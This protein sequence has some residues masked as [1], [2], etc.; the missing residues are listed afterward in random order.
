MN[1]KYG[2]P[3]GIGYTNAKTATSRLAEIVL[4][5]NDAG[6]SCIGSVSM[7]T[8]DPTVLENVKRSNIKTSEYEKMITFLQDHDIPVKSDVMIGLPGQTP[9]TV[10]ADLQ[11]FFDRKVNA[12]I[13]A[14]AI[15]PNSPMGEPEYRDRYQIV[16]AE[17]GHVVSTHSFT[18]SD[19]E[20]IVDI[21]MAY[22]FFVRMSLAKYILYF[23]QI[24]HGVKAADFICARLDVGRSAE[25]PVAARVL[26]QML[27][28][29]R[30]N[31]DF[32]SPSWSDTDAAFL[33]DDLDAF[34][35]E[36]FGIYA[37]RFGAVPEAS[38]KAAIVAAQKSVM[39]NKAACYPRMIE[40]P[41]DVVGY[42]EQLR[43]VSD[44]TQ[45]GTEPLTSFGPGVLQL[46][47]QNSP[48]TYAHADNRFDLAYFEMRSNL[49][50]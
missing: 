21:C 9:D 14:T 47:E 48:G 29:E 18:E 30:T 35:D 4:M 42:F 39:P 24:E 17:T 20:R 3:T 19:Y 22:R 37:A 7:Q 5:L 15:M 49:A 11:F 28:R 32:A 33:F 44:V 46:P 10:L 12:F 23:M 31:P 2:F 26:Q 1:R 25:Y 36:I 40:L 13:F 16:E 27:T 34:Y 45:A 43:R 41:H 50:V 8:I 6:L 38:A